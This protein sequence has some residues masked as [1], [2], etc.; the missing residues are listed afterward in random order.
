VTRKIA[1]LEQEIAINQRQIEKLVSQYK[2][3]E[4]YQD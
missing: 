3:L 4:D 2:P 1:E